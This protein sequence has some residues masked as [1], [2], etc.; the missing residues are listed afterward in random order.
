MSLRVHHAVQ[1]NNEPATIPQMLQDLR[2]LVNS[3]NRI[4]GAA[5][6]ALARTS[7]ICLH[8]DPSVRTKMGCFPW[9]RDR[10][11]FTRHDRIAEPRPEERIAPS[12]RDLPQHVDS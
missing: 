4:R 10:P 8:L 6:R 3:T 1:V 9:K 7:T 5:M 11:Q 2:W 12:R